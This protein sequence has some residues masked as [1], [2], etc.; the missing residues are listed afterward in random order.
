V[1]VVAAVGVAGVAVAATEE[2]EEE[3][4]AGA[5]AQ[6]A[7]A[8]LRPTGAAWWPVSVRPSLNSHPPTTPLTARADKSCGLS[9]WRGVYGVA[10]R[11]ATVMCPTHSSRRPVAAARRHVACRM[12]RNLAHISF[13][14]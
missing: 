1:V 8:G 4:E 13:L 12:I 9:T 5:R 3:E 10:R 6:V 7:L 2:E 11:F 14:A